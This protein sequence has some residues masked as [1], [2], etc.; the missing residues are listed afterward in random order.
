MCEQLGEEPAA[1]AEMKVGEPVEMGGEAGASPRR[2]VIEAELVG[3]EFWYPG[4]SD[5]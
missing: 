5:H 4:G 3:S 2:V 1:F